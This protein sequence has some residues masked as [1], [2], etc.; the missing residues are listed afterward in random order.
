MTAL[1]M[2]QT[3]YSSP[4]APIRTDRGTEYDVF[5]RITHRL[6]S[7]DAKSNAPAFFKA[8]HEN[9]QLWTLLAVD[10]ADADNALPQQLRAQ[11]FYLAEFTL[12]HTSKVLSGE[13]DVE[14][15]IDINTAIMAGLRQKAAAQ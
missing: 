11:I 14:A 12:A 4:S 8:L 7:L 13:E 2:A 10:V 6:K 1:E 5:A 3:A 15:L 9:R